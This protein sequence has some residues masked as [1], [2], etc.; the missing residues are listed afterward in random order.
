[1]EQNRFRFLWHVNLKASLIYINGFCARFFSF[2]DIVSPESIEVSITFFHTNS[3]CVV[4]LC[5][6]VYFLLKFNIDI[7]STIQ[8]FAALRPANF[9]YNHEYELFSSLFSTAGEKNVVFVLVL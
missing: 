8:I 5:I 4:M 9:L 1:M 3:G 2:A 6:S 7:F